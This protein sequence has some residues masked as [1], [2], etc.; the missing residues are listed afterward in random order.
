MPE[1]YGAESSVFGTTKVQ[2]MD[3]FRYSSLCVIYVVGVVFGDSHVEVK[4]MDVMLLLTTSA[5]ATTS[6]T[7][8]PVVPYVLISK[9]VR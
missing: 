9:R 7:V 6:G 1:I 3:F 4:K 8:Q 2:S 5:V